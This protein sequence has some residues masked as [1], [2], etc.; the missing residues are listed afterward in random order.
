MIHISKA[1]SA[2]FEE[3]NKV[4]PQTEQ[5]ISEFQIGTQNDGKADYLLA[6][7][8]TGKIIGKL[9]LKYFGSTESFVHEKITDCPDLENIEVVPE[10]RG[11]GVGTMLI[12]EAEKLCKERGFS[13]VGLGV[14]IENLE[15]RKLYE[16]LGYKDSGLGEFEITFSW[17]EKESDSERE[18][19]ETIVYLIK[20]L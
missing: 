12:Q 18:V 11:Q 6:R 17:K 4:F 19:R 3:L 7:D 2:D 15:A 5:G 8:G 16:K 1:I 10:M 13:K 14:S 9:Y 20:N